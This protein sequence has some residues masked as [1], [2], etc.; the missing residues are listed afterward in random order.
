MEQ[1]HAVH[2]SLIDRS[3]SS[4]TMRYALTILLLAILFNSCKSD[5]STSVNTNQP[6]LVTGS[7]GGFIHILDTLSRPLKW[8][9]GARIQ[10][11]GTSLY[12]IT[13][14][15]GNWQIDNVPQGTHIVSETKYGFDEMKN[16]NITVSGPGLQYYQLQGLHMIPKGELTL[17]SVVDTLI[18][19]HYIMFNIAPADSESITVL[20]EI[21]RNTLELGTTS[22]FLTTVTVL[23]SAHSPSNFSFDGNVLTSYGFPSG[24]SCIVRIAKYNIWA[25]YIPPHGIPV[26]ATNG[27]WSNI[28]KFTVPQ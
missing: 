26:P 25:Y 18:G 13:D 16:Y 28:M 9:D 11:D 8:A 2:Y 15:G 4:N 14:T 6:G 24:Q 20:C 21:A 17:Q 7:I 1:H 3:T 10:V 19:H 12:A 23:L 5:S 22:S 27:P